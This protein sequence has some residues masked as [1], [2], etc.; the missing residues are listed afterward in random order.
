M[1]IIRELE[2]QSRGIYTGTI[3]L[4]QPGG[5]CVFN[6]AIRTVVVDAE[7]GEATF[8]VGGGI[9]IDSTAEGEYDECL[10][11]AKFLNTPPQSFDLFESILL[12]NG[13]YFLIE[14]HLNRLR[15]SAEFFGFQFSEPAAI[16]ALEVLKTDHPDGRCK[17]KLTLKK[18][19]SL[20]TDV[21]AIEPTKL[22]RVGLANSPVDSNDRLLF[23]KTT[24]REF[25]AKQ[26]ESRTDC[27][28]LLFFNEREELTE[29]SVANVVLKLEGKLVTPPVTAGLLAGTFR[30][31]L[32]VD[33]EIEERTIYRYE[34]RQATELFLINSVRKWIK[35][36][37]VEV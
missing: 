11:K 14:R 10:V 9:T 27:D 24:H 19:G 8:G 25:Y 30:E 28:D 36:E 23:H 5:D 32:I 20:V 6:V 35:A 18:D 16:S 29:S 37:L 21:S 15:N 33:G 31:Q 34:L 2:L 26:V 17:V 4:L 3:G 22:W 7:S 1:E 12:E 13:Q